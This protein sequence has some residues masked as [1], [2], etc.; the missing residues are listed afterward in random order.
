MF[1]VHF[2]NVLRQL[3][4][5]CRLT[6]SCAILWLHCRSLADQDCP[7]P[8]RRAG[9][10]L[11]CPWSVLQNPPPHNQLDL[12][13]DCWTETVRVEWS[14]FVLYCS[15]PASLLIE[16]RTV[17]CFLFCLDLIL[18]SCFSC[19]QRIFNVCMPKVLIVEESTFSNVQ[20]GEF[21]L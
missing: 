8:P 15:T 4:D 9:R 1:A 18:S 10:A 13:Q 17:L 14:L 7:T 3:Q 19:L 2:W 6:V 5:T 20:I 21:F 11:P 16:Y 12:Y